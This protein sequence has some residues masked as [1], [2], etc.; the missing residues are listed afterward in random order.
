M[1]IREL[2]TRLVYRVD[3]TQLNAYR[4]QMLGLSADARAISQ[5][6][7]KWGGIM[8][9]T[10]TAPIVLI[11]R[12]M[13]KLASDAEESGSK[14]Q[15]VF[16][17]MKD[18]AGSVAD[19]YAKDF[20][21]ASATARELIGNTGDLLTGFG[22]TQE[23]ALELSDKINRL[24]GDLNSFQNVQ[25]GT[26]E[27]SRKLLSGIL[28]ET[29]GLKT[30]GIVI[31]QDSPEFKKRIETIMRTTGATIQQAK[32]QAIFDEAMKQS[33][34]ALGDY[35]RTRES[36]SNQ[37]KAFHEKRKAMLIEFGKILLP[38]ATEVL[39]IMNRMSDFFLKLDPEIKRMIVGFA[40]LL[41][42]IGPVV[43]ALGG[44]FA[45]ASSYAAWLGSAGSGLGLVAGFTA[46]K[47]ILAPLLIF[48]AKILLVAVAIGLAFDDIYTW[49]KGGDSITGMIL[50]DYESAMK[51]Y[52]DAFESLIGFIVDLMDGNIESLTERILGLKDDMIDASK[53]LRMGVFEELWEKEQQSARGGVGMPMVF[54]NGT[55]MTTKNKP[56]QEWKA[57][58]G[59]SVG[60][61][62]ISV[63]G[64]GNPEATAKAVYDKFIGN[65]NGLARQYESGS[66]T[67]LMLQGVKK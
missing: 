21:L 63:S 64:N 67:P 41:A 49:T 18:Q 10:I 13:V 36:H 25:G 16:R 14:F 22:Y 27:A 20:D 17:D 45:M 35:D 34:N 6:L 58:Q 44:L 4:R 1:T 9:A 29:E 60:S 53:G 24:A 26:A 38:L 47:A 55:I 8:T 39:K 15:V 62:S 32:V 56:Y 48:M 59:L 7:L 23:G 61:V 33:A 51:A 12:E 65:I 30:L 28:G 43:L 37:E 46:L 66:Q 31:R 19:S 3:S 42:I 57:S 2:V 50:G 11:G 54:A 5:S 40:G 52:K